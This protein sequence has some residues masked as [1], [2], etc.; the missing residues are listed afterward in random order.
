M[1][2][3]KK[4][5]ITIQF[6]LIV[7]LVVASSI[8]STH[9]WG[10]KPEAIPD[11]QEL[12]FS[13]SLTVAE[14]GQQNNLP[15]PVLKQVF[16][17][18]N[19]EDLQNKLDTFGLSRS[20]ISAQVDK[21]LALNAEHESKNWKKILAK[22]V[23]WIAFL[24]MVFVLIVTRQITATIRK[25]LYLAAVV[26]F[27]IVL[28]AD[29]SPMGTVKDAIALFGA[30]GVIFLPRMIALTIFLAMVVV[31]N[32]FICSWGCQF[33]VFQDL[34]FR[35]NRNPK[36]RKGI[37]PQYKIP[38]VISNGFRV[39]FFLT[40]T[41]VAF[42]WASDIVNPIDPFKIFKPQTMGLVGVLFVF[43]ILMT[44]LFV[45][46]PWCTLFCPFGLVGWLF[47]KMSLYKICVD[48]ATCTACESCAKACPSPVMEAILKRDRI[49]PDCFSC[50]TC[51]NVCPADSI[52]FSRASRTQPPADKFRK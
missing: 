16:G 38:F 19:K 29:P 1:E 50:G 6:V 36:D 41:F 21:A 4:M 51:I 25:L 28:G 48:Y 49:I 3:S 39:A 52:S 35:L 2:N 44:S 15:Q 37:F 8:I 33:G 26:L 32:K 13:E 10:G 17:L 22:F 45:Y 42:L 27:G 31:A 12:V 40:L 5:S 11:T 24:L 14:F 30:K 43:A 20:N 34:L 23:L 9:F 18:E 47:E 7:G 46:R